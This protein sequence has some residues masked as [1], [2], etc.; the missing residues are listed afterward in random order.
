MIILSFFLTRLQS[1]DIAK[2]S[3]IFDFICYADD[4]TLSSVLNYFG[5]NQSFSGNI[6]TE[7][8]KVHDWLKVNKL[9][10]KVS[11]PFVEN[12]C[13]FQCIKNIMNAEI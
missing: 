6:N 2:S 9:S 1:S 5:N 7:L 8:E 11:G 12:L 10:L 13:V 3:D 4:T